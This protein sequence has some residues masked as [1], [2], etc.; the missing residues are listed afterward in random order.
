MIAFILAITLIAIALIS[1]IIWVFPWGG[2]ISWTGIVLIVILW[3]L[4]IV[5]MWLM[6]EFIKWMKIPTK[7]MIKYIGFVM[8]EYYRNPLDFLFNQDALKQRIG[9]KIE[10]LY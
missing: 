8:E 1:L 10:G 4:T 9:E 6:L 7:N 2:W 3:L 5:A